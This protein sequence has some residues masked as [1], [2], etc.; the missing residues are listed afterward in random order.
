MYT[1]SP[2]Y[3]PRAKFLARYSITYKL[4]KDYNITFLRSCFRISFESKWRRIRVYIRRYKKK[5]W[6]ICLK[7][8]TRFVWKILRTRTRNFVTK[9]EQSFSYAKGKKRNYF[10]KL[11]KLARFSL[12]HRGIIA[13]RSIEIQNGDVCTTAADV[14]LRI[15]TYRLIAC[16]HPKSGDEGFSSASRIC[17]RIGQPEIIS[18]PISFSRQIPSDNRFSDRVY[19]NGNRDKLKINRSR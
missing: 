5:M 19:K 13:F 12:F 7:T 2:F 15:S 8:D 17:Q 11:I 1:V 4:E 16:E 18:I 3:H 9:A 6:K 10:K 14:Q